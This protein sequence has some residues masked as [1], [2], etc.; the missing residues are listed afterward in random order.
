ME[1]A[2]PPVPKEVDEHRVAHNLERAIRPLRQDREDGEL[3]QPPTLENAWRYRNQTTREQHR[4]DQGEAEQTDG[5]QH[6]INSFTPAGTDEIRHCT[7]TTEDNPIDKEH[8]RERPKNLRAKEGEAGERAKDVDA[9]SPPVRWVTCSEVAE[10]D[11]VDEQHSDHNQNPPSPAHI[12]SLGVGQLTA[13]RG[14]G[15]SG[16]ANE[17]RPR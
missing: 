8:R 9:K 1:S 10:R 2:V 4:Y 6:Q 14:R 16:Q 3:V 17:R 15:A 12:Q 5:C 7:S 11:N 13:T